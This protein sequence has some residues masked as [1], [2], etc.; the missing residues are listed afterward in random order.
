[1][2][3]RRWNPDLHPRDA[4]GRFVRRGSHHVPGQL[5]IDT[6][7]AARAEQ[8]AQRLREANQRRSAAARERKRE[9]ARTRLRRLH[10]DDLADEFARIS[11]SEYLDEEAM[12]DVLAEMERRDHGGH[13]EE[14]PAIVERDRRIDALVA[15]GMEYREAYAEVLGL[16]SD[17]LLRQ[18]RRS[19]VQAERRP[20]ETLDQAVNRM[21]RERV[22]LQLVAAEDFARGHLLNAEGRAEGVDP[23]WMFSGPASR[24]RYASPE[25]LEFWQTQQPRQTATEFRA[26]MLGRARDVAAAGRTAN[27]VRDRELQQPGDRRG[28]PR[29]RRRPAAEAPAPAVVEPVRRT[30]E[31][32][33]A[34][35]AAASAGGEALGSPRFGLSQRPRPPEFTPE[36]SH[37]VYTYSGSEYNAVNRSLRGQ[38]MPYGYTSDD[39]API[40]DGLDAAMAASHLANDVQVWRGVSD[41]QPL[42]GERLAG[43][44]TGM[45]WREDA[46]LST[47]VSQRRASGFAGGNNGVLM[48]ILAPAGTPAVEVSPAEQ[49]GEILFGRGQRLRV[50]RDTWTSTGIRQLDVEVINDGA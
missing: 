26:D 16:D 39:V 9:T 27:A 30:G 43:D 47:S 15:Q 12:H 1:M 49:E 29:R 34:D 31:Q 35:A 48:R 40:V 36:M 46:M 11:G 22:A 37:A 33:D 25:L 23:I 20:G 3:V 13:R 8:R 50:V 28:T 7:R 17:E 2:G 14:D 32:F 21:Y 44:L 10:D 45:E 5:E 41:A 4:R 18:E 24:M 42:F 19:L 6:D 38:T